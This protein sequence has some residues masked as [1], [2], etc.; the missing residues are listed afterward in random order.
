MGLVPMS[1]NTRPSDLIMPFMDDCFSNMSKTTPCAGRLLLPA[2]RPEMRETAKDS[3]TFFHT[4]RQLIEKISRDRGGGKE[5]HC[6]LLQHTFGVFRL[7]S[8]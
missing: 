5:W 2:N 3:V 6:L 8:P 1:P 4:V 7:Y